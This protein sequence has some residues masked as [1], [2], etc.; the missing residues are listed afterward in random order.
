[1]WF[2]R[3]ILIKNN[4]QKY[5]FIGL[6]NTTI[7]YLNRYIMLLPFLSRFENHEFAFFKI[8]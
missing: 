6:Y 5:Y 2:P 3:K 8:N 4:T 7:V 1:M